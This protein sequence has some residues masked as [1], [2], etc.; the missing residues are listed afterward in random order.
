MKDELRALYSKF[1][2]LASHEKLKSAHK[3]TNTSLY[4]HIHMSLYIH[5][6]IGIKTDGSE[7]VR[8]EAAAIS[9]VY[10]QGQRVI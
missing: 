9:R 6:Y 2:M 4:I 1:N 3:H 5:V 10:T 7:T 8:E